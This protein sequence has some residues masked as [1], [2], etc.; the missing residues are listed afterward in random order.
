MTSIK[1]RYP[2]NQVGH[3]GNELGARLE[4]SHLLRHGQEAREKIT[5]PLSVQLIFSNEMITSSYN[6][7]ARRTLV[8]LFKNS[9]Q[10]EASNTSLLIIMCF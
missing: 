8:N 4:K 5:R 2:L 6:S 3:V 9:F 7:T 1:G 10:L